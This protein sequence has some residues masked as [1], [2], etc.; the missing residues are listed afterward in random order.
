MHRKKIFENTEAISPI[1][2][3]ILLLAVAV[4]AGM[5]LYYWFGTF[6]SGA[7]EQVQN[8]ST[9]SM[10]I[11]AEKSIVLKVSL[12]KDTF[13]YKSATLLDADNDGILGI[14]NRTILNPSYVNSWRD[15]RFIQ[16]IPIYI[17]NQ[18][19]SELTGVK[20]K[21]EPTTNIRYLRID[22]NNGNQLLKLDGTPAK[23]NFTAD[24]PIEKEKDI[25]YYFN[26]NAYIVNYTDNTSAYPS[27]VAKDGNNTLFLNMFYNEDEQYTYARA[28]KGGT[29]LG[30][31]TAATFGRSTL[32]LS[33]FEWFLANLQNP[34]YDVGTLKPGES[35]KVYTYF[36]V[37]DGFTPK[38]WNCS[39]FADCRVNLPVTVGT[40]Q[41]V[42]QKVT[43]TLHL[44][45]Q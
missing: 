11:M 25:T 40:D 14:G 30:W 21:Y 3:T 26:S 5:G 35:K 38:Q 12:P 6:Q 13:V 18:G 19:P 17:K 16:E 43:V 23:V 20:I 15:E 37:G 22:R 4:A 36:M 33:N 41:G 10:N 32:N 42:S 39:S 1:V 2:A 9:A 8:S 34:N 45:D 31:N 44:M 28:E 29:S 7:Q 27:F 24:G